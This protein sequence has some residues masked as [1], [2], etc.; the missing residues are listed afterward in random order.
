[1]KFVGVDWNDSP[2]VRSLYLLQRN[3][4]HTG[5]KETTWWIVT[6]FCI[7]DRITYATFGDDRLSCLGVARGRISRFPLTCV[8]A[9]TRL[10]HYRASALSRT[11]VPVCVC[12]RFG[13]C[14]PWTICKIK[15]KRFMRNMIHVKLLH[16]SYLTLA[17]YLFCIFLQSD[18]A[19]TCPAGWHIAFKFEALWHYCRISVVAVDQDCIRCGNRCRVCDRVKW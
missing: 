17:H 4:E 11:T 15:G 13:G 3:F 16:A 18:F 12:D 9:L 7:Q 5:I 1:M 2:H 10:S 8:V 19:L 14:I 6:K